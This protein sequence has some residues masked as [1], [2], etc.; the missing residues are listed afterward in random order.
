MMNPGPPKHSP[1][2]QED[3]RNA[4]SLESKELE[5]TFRWLEQH[6]PPSFSQEVVFEKRLI[7]AKSLQSFQIQGRFV[8]IRLK[9]MAI[10]LCPN[11]P[12][13][14][15][16]ILKTYANYVIHYYRTFLSDAPPPGETKEV[17]RIA[18]LYLQ[19][20]PKEEPGVAQAIEPE[21]REELIYLIQ[22][23]NKQFHATDL[24]TLLHGMTPRFVRSLKN[25]R[26]ALALDMYFRAKT[27]D[28]C[29]YEIRRNED[30]QEKNLPSL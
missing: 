25:G 18:I 26:L 22:Q 13:V 15:L 3:L 23:R 28:E 10:I 21:R 11:A 4:I 8:N 24:E 5:H 20:E 19:G 7:I 12:D 16:K 9:H 17:L 1:L 30:W 27:S 14:D 6:L 2:S 29:Q